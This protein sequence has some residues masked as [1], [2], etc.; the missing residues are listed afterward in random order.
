MPPACVS[1]SVSGEANT[2]TESKKESLDSSPA[3]YA[4]GFFPLSAECQLPQFHHG[5][6]VFCH[7]STCQ[8]ERIRSGL[9]VQSTS[10]I[11]VCIFPKVLVVWTLMLTI[12]TCHSPSDSFF[13]KYFN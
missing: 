12:R 10:L 6:P 2:A 11:R 7:E 3:F 5:H 1:E 9:Q 13:M 4:K 8:I